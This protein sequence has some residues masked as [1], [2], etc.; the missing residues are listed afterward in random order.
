MK[1][2]WDWGYAILAIIVVSM[3]TSILIGAVLGYNLE[4][5]R[6]ENGCVENGN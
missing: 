1:F 5:K 3:F 2:K 4:V 6:I